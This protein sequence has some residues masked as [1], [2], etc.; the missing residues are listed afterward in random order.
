MFTINSIKIWRQDSNS[1]PEFWTGITL[2]T[3]SLNREE[4]N[5]NTTK[6]ILTHWCKMKLM[7]KRILPWTSRVLL[8]VWKT[9]TSHWLT[10]KSTRYCTVD[11]IWLLSNSIKSSITPSSSSWLHLL[12]SCMVS[13]IRMRLL[14]VILQVVH[15]REE[16][17]LLDQIFLTIRPWLLLVSWRESL[18]KF[19]LIF[20]VLK[21]RVKISVLR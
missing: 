2:Q 11:M 17:F 18:V 21:A 13:T 3:T 9:F 8:N 4:E 7:P 14:M 10:P 19:L 5:R 16:K 15:Q 20:Q 12:R 1:S 6:A